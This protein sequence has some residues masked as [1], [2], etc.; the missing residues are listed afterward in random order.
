M[1]TSDKE[2]LKIKLTV[3]KLFSIYLFNIH[4]FT[5]L[6]QCKIEFI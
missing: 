2:L 5:T 3:I 1:L 4:S 6:Q